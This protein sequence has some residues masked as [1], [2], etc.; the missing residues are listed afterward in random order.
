[1]RYDIDL[2]FPITRNWHHYVCTHNPG[3]VIRL[4]NEPTMNLKC[5]SI[6]VLG[7]VLYCNPLQNVTR[8]LMLALCTYSIVGVTLM[9]WGIFLCHT[10]K[11][12]LEPMLFERLKIT[13]HF[14]FSCQ[15]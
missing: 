13:I 5:F 14:A 6:E 4:V 10:R 2:I 12:S 1:M 7:L 11:H 3:I 9:C 8:C 15:H